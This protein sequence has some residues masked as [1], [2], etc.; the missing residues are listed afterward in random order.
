MTN[1]YIMINGDIVPYE[2]ATIH[3]ASVAMKYGASVFEGIRGYWNSSNKT[4]NIFLL[5]EHIRRLL[6]S[7]KLMR[8]KHNYSSKDISQFIENLVRHNLLKEDCYIRCAASIEGEGGIDVSDPVM[9]S[10][11]AFPQSRKAKQQEGIHVSI[12]SWIRIS[13]TMMPPRI[14]CIANYQNGRLA[15]LQA[16]A[17]GYD[18]TILLNQNGKIAEAPTACIFLVKNGIL[19]TPSVTQ[20]ILESITRNFIIEIAEKLNLSCKQQDIDRSEC[21]L[22]DEIFL[23][24]TGVEILPV[25]S[26]DR[27]TVG[28]GIIG[29][30]TNQLKLYYYDTVYEKEY[31]GSHYLYPVSF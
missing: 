16:K 3:V 27:F 26:V 10:I 22:A 17:D 6:E 13:D 2:N 11:D 9:L 12:S 28:K 14:K 23:C 29:N 1:R 7:M 5:N 25:V 21:Y 24:G 15:T 31:N 30:I 4:L 18:N 20:G 8:M 19:I